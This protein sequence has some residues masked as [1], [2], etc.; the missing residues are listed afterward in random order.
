MAFAG[1]G[2]AVARFGLDPGEVRLSAYLG[3]VMVTVAAL[4][5]VIGYLQY[6]ELLA[7]EMA[8]LTDLARMRA[9]YPAL[10]ALLDG[11]GQLPPKP[12]QRPTGR[13]GSRV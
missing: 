1:L 10:A 13:P 7:E 5:T 6:R 8:P 2:F 12:A 4:M 11:R 3:I 9:R